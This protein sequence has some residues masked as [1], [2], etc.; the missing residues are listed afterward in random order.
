MLGKWVPAD[1]VHLCVEQCSR[2]LFRVCGGMTAEQLMSKQL[3]V[4]R[5]CHQNAPSST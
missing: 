1:S 2:E 3:G 5:G 4:K